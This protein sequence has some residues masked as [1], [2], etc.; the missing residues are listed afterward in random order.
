MFNKNLIFSLALMCCFSIL[1]G[2]ASNLTISFTGSGA[3]T[4]VDSVIVQNLTKSTNVKVPSGNVLSLTSTVTSEIS[5]C[6]EN[7]TILPNPI[8]TTADLNFYASNCGST[9]VKVYNLQ[10]V[11]VVGS[12]QNLLAGENSVQITLPRG[13]YLIRVS[14]VGYNY[15]TKAISVSESNI[16]PSLTFSGNKQ[17][18]SVAFTPQKSKENADAIT[19]LQYSAGDRLLYKAY[20]L[21][22]YCTIVTDVPTNDKTTNFNFVA[23]AD[24]NG[25]NYAVVTIGAQT[26]MAENLKTT[27]Y[28][29]NVSIPNVT[30]STWDNLS[31]GAWCYY[32]N[33]SINSK[34]GKLYNWYAASD[35]RNI[36]PVGW[37]VS[38][39]SEWTTLENY[40]I[41]NGYN[42]DG[43][44]IDNKIAKAL[45]ATTDWTD[46]S[47]AG[48]IGNILSLNN[49]TGFGALPAG[50]R[51]GIF[52]GVGTSCLWWSSD[53]DS[54]NQAYYSAIANNNNYVYN[55][56]FYESQG[57][58]VR[59]VKD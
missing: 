26:W 22:K 48:T 8:Q 54:Y 35:S 43:T 36:A 18:S 21:G 40:L 56:H 33:N 38:T 30:S 4:I 39:S 12:T 25:N 45:A 14:G 3:S 49:S 46:D 7:M 15:T 24:A 23:C 32:D 41:S 1:S 11:E 44:I 13:T 16:R 10:G 50:S 47:G 55:S 58:S 27:K 17:L 6:I 53:F 31:T 57:Y 28:R 9:T 29:N 59:C 52:Y 34:Y 20:S 51:Q 19:T 5:S 42:Y 2:F 37:H